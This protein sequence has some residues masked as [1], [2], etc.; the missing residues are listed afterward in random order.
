MPNGGNGWI[1]ED[2]IFYRLNPY[3]WR[4]SGDVDQTHIP[5]SKIITF[6]VACTLVSQALAQAPAQ[7]AES[8]YQKGLAAEKAGDPAAARNF[9]TEALKADPKN[10]NA[11]FS[12]G[13]LKLTSG[14][15]AAK[16]REAKFG[17][18]MIPVF[19]L[20]AAT[21]KDSLDALSLIIE[22]QS[23]EEVTPNF[24]IEDPKNLLGERKISLNL[25]NMPAQAVMK[26]LLDQTGAKVR[27]DEHAVVI[28]P[29]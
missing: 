4:V 9:Y 20:D 1:N 23:K 17:A 2:A 12:L 3:D 24:V 25:K 13:Q 18:V 29:R 14:S 7:S 5:M 16:G 22:K 26:Y 8:L 11:R 19:Q 6:V 28:S 27:Y 10:A 15:I 21:L